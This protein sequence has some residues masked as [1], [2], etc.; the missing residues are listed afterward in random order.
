MPAGG[1][2]SGFEP[3]ESRCARGGR[4]VDREPVTSGQLRQVKTLSEDRIGCGQLKG[5]PPASCPDL[6]DLEAAAVEVERT[7]DRPV[8]PVIGMNV[9]QARREIDFDLQVDMFD[10]ALR[11][12]GVRMW[13]WRGST[14]SWL[15]SAIEFAS[16]YP[17]TLSLDE[18]Q[19][20][21]PGVG[22]PSG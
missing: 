16:R 11:R 19:C 10:P 14:P 2:V 6:S 22:G 8:E 18:G 3:L 9:K 17:D 1:S 5:Y 20:K 7:S 12:I 21:R 4:Q 13:I 15:R